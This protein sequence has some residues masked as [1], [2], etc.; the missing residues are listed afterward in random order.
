[1]PYV[2]Q[3]LRKQL[4][5]WLNGLSTNLAWLTDNGKKNNGVV[6]YVLYKIL[7]DVYSNGNYEI[8]SNAIKVLE[9][10]KLEFYRRIISPYEDS[11]IN[12]NGDV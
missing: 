8:L 3:K 12:S 6:T 11:K 1:M 5:K 9:T 10:T 2:E 7:K 4:A